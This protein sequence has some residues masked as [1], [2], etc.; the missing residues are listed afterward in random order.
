MRSI[1][2]PPDPG[3]ARKGEDLEGPKTLQPEKKGK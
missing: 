3:E 2:S 1:T